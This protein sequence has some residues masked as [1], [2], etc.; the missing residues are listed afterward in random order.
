MLNPYI[1]LTTEL[2][3]AITKQPTWFVRQYYERGKDNCNLNTTPLLFSHYSK[4]GIDKERAYRHFELIK[5]DRY[6][7]IYDSGNLKDMEKLKMASLQPGG[8]KIY[9]NVMRTSWT[10]PKTIRNKV[11][12]YLKEKFALNNEP[13]KIDL[14]DLFGKLYL[15]I[16]WKGTKLEVL[17]DEVENVYENV[18]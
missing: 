1:L 4:V 16:S 2:L 17:L 6:R 5:N 12:I 9:T 10:A 7:F 14:Q 8:Y 18:L 11:Y 3:A 15:R 13:V